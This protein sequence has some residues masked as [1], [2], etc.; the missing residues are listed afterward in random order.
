MPDEVPKEV[1]VSRRWKYGPKFCKYRRDVSYYLGQRIVDYCKSMGRYVT[2]I[3]TWQDRERTWTTEWRVW[4]TLYDCALPRLL[5][6]LRL[7]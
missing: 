2:T 7:Q 6:G 1:F 3:D 5:R 4:E